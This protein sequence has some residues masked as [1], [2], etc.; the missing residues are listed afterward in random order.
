MFRLIRDSFDYIQE[1][2]T[3]DMEIIVANLA[4]ADI[5]GKIHARAW[6]QAYRDLFPAEYLNQ[7]SE[8]KR[9]EEFLNSRNRNN[10]Y[11]VMLE[12][13]TYVGMFK[14]TLFGDTC[15]ISSI[16]ILDEY[17][18]KGYGS[19]CMNYIKSKYSKYK[20]VLWT[21]EMNWNARNFYEKHHFYDTDERRIIYR[22]R[23]YIQVQY[24]L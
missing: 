24:A 22:G 16:Y 6:K 18:H 8:Q 12:E 4:H 19:I 14:I 21:L 13:D 17:C 10:H 3:T 9:K 23:Q 5:I 15:E 2:E 11:Y 20:I 1:E 7:E